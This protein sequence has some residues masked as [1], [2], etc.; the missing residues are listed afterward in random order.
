MLNRYAMEVHEANQ[1]WW[2][3][4]ETGE[5]L[6]RNKAEMIALMHSEL[7]EMLEG[8]RK[9]LMDDHLP[10]L[11]SE[12]VELADL[13]IRAFDYAGG[14]G[15]DLDEAYREKMAYNRTR[16]DHTHEHRRGEHGKKI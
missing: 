5:R 6:V 11:T 15:I 14:H 10:H 1:K 12:A 3:D 9:N 4:L 13:M 7:S 16:I 8:V 2:H